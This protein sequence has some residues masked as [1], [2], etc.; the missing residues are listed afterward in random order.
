[1]KKLLSILTLMIV[2]LSSCSNESEESTFKGMKGWYVNLKS[3]ARTS[4]FNRINQAI[5][6]NELLADYRHVDYYATRDLFFDEYGRWSCTAA[7]YGA[8]RFQPEGY[9]INV[10]EIINDNTL[11]FHGAWLWD[12]AYVPND[13]EII[14]AVYGGK[15][16]GDLVYVS[17]DPI[18]YSYTILENK[19]IVSNGDIYT[20]GEGYLIKDGSSV[21]MT[22]YNPNEKF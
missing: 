17:E 8:C 3:V 20:F 11:R 19:I 22:K 1:M 16:I 4:D 14:G 12:P 15:E 9:L 7:H 18:V 5:E 13:A 10:V 21:T 6:D 2:V